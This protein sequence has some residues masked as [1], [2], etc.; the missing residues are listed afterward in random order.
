[1][2]AAV[3]LLGMIV[4]TGC[5][6]AQNMM[7]P[8][9]TEPA[10][11]TLVG[12]MKKDPAEKPAEPAESEKEDSAAEPE[13][14]TEPTPPADTTPPTVI[15]VAW[16]SDWQMTKPLTTDS[17][18]RPEDTVYTRVK[19]SEPVVH[20]VAKDKTARPVLFIAIN[21][22]ATRYRMLPHG[23]GFQSGEAKPLHDRTENYLCKY[24]IPTDTVGTLALRV[25]VK[26]ADMAGN[27]VAKASVHTAPFTITNPYPVVTI[28]SMIPADDRSV[29]I[30][31]TSADLPAET[32]VIVTIDF[33]TTTTTTDSD[34]N[35][36]VTVSAAEI[37]PLTAG[38]KTVTASAA[39]TSDSDSFF[40]IK[41]APS[42]PPPPTTGEITLVEVGSD[43][44]FTLEGLTYPGYNPSPTV[45]HI[46]DTHPSAELPNFEEAVK[47]IEVVDWVYR[48]VW[49]VYPDWET[50]PASVD[51]MVAARDRVRR[52]FGLTEKI[53][54][55]LFGMYF[56]SLGEYPESSYW[57]FVECY[58]LLLTYPEQLQ[59]AYP[60]SEYNELRRRFAES[61]E[62]GYIVGETNPND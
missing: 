17:T 29:T 28:V 13:K 5:P 43:Y 36:T 34:G 32:E 49:E 38:V 44:T 62:K 18:V 33:I 56:D 12:D 35:W 2:I 21:D 9:V 8:V 61:L 40:L 54:G 23:V 22:M 7:E 31:G 39:D 14:P 48:K 25:G 47:M 11:T 19:F 10:D 59:L 50:N 53:W 45:Q 58:R 57:F 27:T 41:P 55:T 1:M 6:E 30:S 52:Q 15:E 42:E 16:Y 3:L 26:T 51:K 37:E 20:T 24:T 60:E 4:L 46:L